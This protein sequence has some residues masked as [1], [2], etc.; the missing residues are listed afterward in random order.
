MPDPD[1]VAQGFFDRMPECGTIAWNT[2][3][4][5]YEQNGDYDDAMEFFQR[6]QEVGG[7]PDRHT[8]SS[9]LAACASLAMLNLGVQLHQLMEK[10][11]LPD[12]ATSI[13]LITMYSRCGELANAKAI[14]Y[15][16]THKDLVSCNALIGCYEHNG[17]AIEALRLFEDMRSSKVMSTHNFHFSLECLWK[18]WLVAEAIRHGY[19]YVYQYPTDMDTVIRHFAKQHDTRIRLLFFKNIKK[20]PAHRAPKTAQYQ[21]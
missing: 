5:G 12:I 13:A 17:C 19:G 9:V 15:Q 8:L 4:S 18:C 1:V 14:F 2:M 16:M 6:M 10:S 7:R 20:R 3:I 21:I 11:F